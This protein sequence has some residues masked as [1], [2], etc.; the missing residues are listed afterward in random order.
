MLIAKYMDLVYGAQA[1]VGGQ[2]EVD[3][4]ITLQAELARR[5]GITRSS[6]NG[7]EMGLALPSTALLVELAR[8]FHVSTDYLLGLENGAVLCMDGLSGREVA[9]VRELVDCL[10]ARK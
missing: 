8:T 6:V 9:A 1:A 5:L 3:V 7:W 2:P 10:H 4:V